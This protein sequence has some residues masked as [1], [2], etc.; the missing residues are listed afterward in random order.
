VIARAVSP[1][2]D[3]PPD[4]EPAC[5]RCRGGGY[6][7]RNVAVDHPDFGRLVPCPC[8]AEELQ[9]LRRSRLERLS[10][11]GPL[12]RLTFDTLHPE[13]RSA[14]PARQARFR[15]IVD[16]A[17]AFAAEPFGWLL[18]AGP[19]GS[20]KTHLAAAVANAR[21]ASGES[22]VFVVVPDLLDHL[23]AAYAPTSEL[24][25]DELFE[26]IRE[27]P[28]LVLDDLG[29]QS[30]TPWAQE[31]LFQL[32]NHRYNSRL[33]TVVTT[34]FRP[35]E[36]DERLR[37][38]LLD[39]SLTTLAIVDDWEA[40]A[41]QRLGGLGLERLGEMT[42]ASF[43]QHGFSVDDHQRA[44]MRDVFKHARGFAQDPAGWLV[45]QGVPGTG[46][47]HLAVAIANERVGAGEPAYFVTA[48]DLLD[49]LRAAYGPESKVSY[50]KVFEAVRSTPLLILD[51][52]G[53]QSS[54]PWAQE[55]LFQLLNYRYN[56]KLP[57][58]I[59]TNLL[60]EDLDP[61]ICSRMLDQRLSTV[62]TLEI[63]PYRLEQPR[64]RGGGPPRASWS[65]RSR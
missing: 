50:D 31:K 62:W 35:E 39:P 21:L 32:F 43:D 20:G 9:A 61:R 58:V 64:A 49:H 48:P 6:L 38:R 51:D 7:R 53:A 59:T 25:Y 65:R 17:R 52:L 16:G 29:T 44:R 12:V 2:A 40:S 33:P 36:L 1:D 47:T 28:L 30:G 34:N 27:T 14:E 3:P 19:P 15:G 63:P 60:L 22:V 45:L 18:L 10:N 24:R 37:T 57:T 55:K 11:L 23:R 13:G 8:R 56:A 4:E 54:T 26:S 41:L 5:P 42:F 46:K